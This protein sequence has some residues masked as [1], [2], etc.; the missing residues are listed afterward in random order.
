[1]VAWCKLGRYFYA[2]TGTMIHLDG[3][4]CAVFSRARDRG[5]VS[6]RI[7]KVKAIII[8][9]TLAFRTKRTKHKFCLQT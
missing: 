9:T 2:K 6:T 5:L 4:L 7:I 8:A 3:V 1:M